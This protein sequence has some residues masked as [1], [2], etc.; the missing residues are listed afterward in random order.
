[1]GWKR[2][3][4]PAYSK[5]LLFIAGVLAGITYSTGWKLDIALAISAILICL[6]SVKVEQHEKEN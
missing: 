4:Q 1:M 2:F 6:L 3:F 5:L